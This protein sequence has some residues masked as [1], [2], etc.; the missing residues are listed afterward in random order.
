MSASKRTLTAIFNN[1]LQAT[2]RERRKA[3]RHTITLPVQVSGF[4]HDK[5]PWHEA[6]DT[7]NISSGG[8]ALRLAR[9]VMIGEL[10]H[11]AVSLPPRWR[12]DAEKS[13]GHK[14]YA[15][16]RHIE[17]RGGGQQI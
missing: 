14:S 17:W 13:A 7:E 5:R 4:D 16:V 15:I 3:A 9:P 6:A 1:G 11:V 2:K 12:K 10:L 8:V